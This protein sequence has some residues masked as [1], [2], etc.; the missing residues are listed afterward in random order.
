MTSIPGV[1]AHPQLQH[2]LHALAA[3]VGGA[4][5]KAPGANV[6]LQ[7]QGHQL[8]AP[9][10]E[11]D[12]VEG[13]EVRPRGRLHQAQAQVSCIAV[14]QILEKKKFWKDQVFPPCENVDFLIV[15]K[16]GKNCGN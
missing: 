7:R 16:N 14:L 13:V 1:L 8:L 11:A 9:R 12:P 6:G 4:N 2:V 5:A 15:E 3:L 10:V